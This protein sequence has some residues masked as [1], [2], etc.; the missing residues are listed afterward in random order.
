[1]NVIHP[2]IRERALSNRPVQCHSR[3]RGFGAA[4]LC[5]GLALGA[6]GS[7]LA[8]QDGS[9]A[10]ET[11]DHAA[12]DA[13]T[14]T[15]VIIALDSAAP[16]KNQQ[17]AAATV[18]G[19]VTL[20]GTVRDEQSKQ[21]AETVADRIA[22]V[23]SVVNRLTVASPSGNESPAGAAGAANHEPAATEVATIDQ[24][25][26]PDIQQQQEQTDQAQDQA[27]VMDQ[28]QAQPQ[29]AP[30]QQAPNQRI[31]NQPSDNQQS[32][33]QQPPM[34]QSAQGSSASGS[35]QMQDG[36]A[37]GSAQASQPQGSN[38]PY[39]YPSG[40]APRMDAGPGDQNGY[41]NPPQAQNGP[42]DA[43]Q[44]YPQGPQ[45]S[46]G[47]GQNGRQPY[48]RGSNGNGSYGNGSYGDGS[49]GDRNYGAY[50]DQGPD[51]DGNRS[52]RNDNRNSGPVTLPAATM[53]RVRTS[54]FLDV[55]KLQP[56]SMFEVTAAN[57]VF[58][59]GVLAV[60]RGAVLDGVVTDVK[61][62]SSGSMTGASSLS[63]KLTSLNLE[64]RS[65]SL[66][67]DLWTGNGPGKGAYS[68]NNT[69]GGAAIGA[70]I[71]AVIGR[72]P[73]AAIGAVAGGATGAAASSASA[74][75]RMV[76]A[77]ETILTFHLTQPVTVN[78]VSNQEA[79]RL[80]SAAQPARPYLRQ[81]GYYPPPPPPPP[82]YYG[83]VYYRPY[84]Y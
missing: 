83:R 17:I 68:A 19:D 7:A 10:A 11:A 26:R 22:G 72:G 43:N 66:A 73:G 14:E 46:Y 84:W 53:L 76:L 80:A 40:P 82:Y 38:A 35:G 2:I 15:N 20:T 59:G 79:Q 58:V 47:P 25:S 18:D 16:L 55:K 54:E 31:E 69:I 71:G 34:Q 32:G 4:V 30:S 48:D 64:G 62:S 77:P 13:K 24:T 6:S 44:G 42:A 12:Q 9:P 21:M 28:S 23:R 65:Y 41:P 36:S 57:D 50:G 1:M 33:A 67:T 63:L 39:P 52:R 3:L 74:G 78:P 81:R 75:P 27:P 29:Q 61:S 70:V 37:P 45:P 8:Q 51:G 56:G 5:L 49:Y 60:P